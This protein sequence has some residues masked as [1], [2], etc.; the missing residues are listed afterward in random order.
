MITSPGL[1]HH[2]INAM[3]NPITKEPTSPVRPSPV[4][5]SET[6]AFSPVPMNIERQSETYPSDDELLALT[7]RNTSSP[8][9][10]EPVA[11]EP[12]ASES[13]HVQPVETEAVKAVPAKQE[14]QKQQWPKN[15]LVSFNC[16]GNTQTSFAQQPSF[17]EGYS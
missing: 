9:R 15:Y 4:K 5:A 13:I 3:S 11:A 16:S 12:I 14:K 1:S 2:S 10:A 6:I 7:A 8:V 17:G